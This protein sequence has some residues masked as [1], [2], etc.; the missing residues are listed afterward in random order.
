[1]SYTYNRVFSHIAKQIAAQKH[2]VN[3]LNLQLSALMLCQ[4][5]CDCEMINEALENKM[6]GL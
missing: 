3:I 6:R 2:S 5:E 1:M 4:L